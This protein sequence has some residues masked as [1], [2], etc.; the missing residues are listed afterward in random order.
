MAIDLTAEEAD[1]LIK[2]LKIAEEN[3]LKVDWK[4]VA[5]QNK[6]AIDFLAIPSNIESDIKFK[7]KA[8][9]RNKISFALLLNGTNIALVR[10]DKNFHTNPDGTKLTDTHIHI[11]K[12]G[13]EDKWAY[14]LDDFDLSD[15]NTSFLNFL[16]RINFEKTTID[17]KGSFI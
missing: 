1:K 4:F 12:E 10:I 3:G 14:P 15:P 13:F 9:K 7:I 2:L 17:F 8:N 11:Y 5:G 16:D 6:Y